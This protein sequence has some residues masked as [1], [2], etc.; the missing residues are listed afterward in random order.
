VVYVLPCLLPVPLQDC[1]AALPCRTSFITLV[2]D[3]NI[4]LKGQFNP[5][6]WNNRELDLYTVRQ[7]LYEQQHVTWIF[8]QKLSSALHNK[9]YCWH[10]VFSASGC[11][12]FT[13]RALVSKSSTDGYV[14]F[15]RCSCSWWSTCVAATRPCAAPTAGLTCAAP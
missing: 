7:G 9:F 15:V 5:P 10:A 13:S 4:H 1:L 3:Y 12:C 2:A 14:V 11:T 6:M 8:S